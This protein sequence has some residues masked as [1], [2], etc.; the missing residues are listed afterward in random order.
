MF[1][2]KDFVV[3]WGHLLVI[4][5]FLIP[6]IVAVKDPKEYNIPV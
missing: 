1:E 2:M 4:S 6:H 5:L 3:T